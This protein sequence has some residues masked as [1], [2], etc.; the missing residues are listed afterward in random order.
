MS[1][2]ENLGYTPLG[3]NGTAN[4]L[5]NEEGQEQQVYAKWLMHYCICYAQAA[6]GIGSKLLTNLSLFISFWQ[7][8]CDYLYLT[9]TTLLPLIL[10]F[11][12]EFLLYSMP[13]H[14]K[15]ILFFRRVQPYQ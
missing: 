15:K 4:Q 9:D 12:E 5:K 2:I 6:S 8:L 13:P 1:K 14:L 3:S 11:H 10:Y 7:T